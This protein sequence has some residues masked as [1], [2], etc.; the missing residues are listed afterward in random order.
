[1]N[2]NWIYGTRSDEGIR[3]RFF[4]GNESDCLMPEGMLF[5]LKLTAE[6]PAEVMLIF[7]KG[8]DSYKIVYTGIHFAPGNIFK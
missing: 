2:P 1:M 7:L 5:S 4:C 8:F 6:L 3:D